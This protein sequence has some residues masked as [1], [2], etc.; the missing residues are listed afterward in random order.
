MGYVGVEVSR[1]TGPDL[2]I[3]NLST[4]ER[5][6]LLERL[7]DSLSSTPDAIP[8]TE[9]QRDELDR[10]IEEMEGSQDPDLSW[11]EVVRPLPRP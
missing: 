5:L 10:R 6:L 8:L 4:E 1:V 2:D 7:W 3:E 9:A 11:D